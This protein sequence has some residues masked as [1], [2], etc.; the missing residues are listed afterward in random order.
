MSA[1]FTVQR[2]VR[3]KLIRASVLCAG[4]AL[5]AACNPALDWR[6]YHSDEGGYS[7]LL[8]QKPGRAQR[9]LAT[10]AGQVTMQMLSAQ[11]DGML[12]GAASANFSVPPDEATQQAMRA[13]LLKNIDGAVVSD[14]PVT[15]AGNSAGRSAGAPATLT[16]REV[17]KRGSFGSGERAAQG[18][19]RARFF[20]RG[21]RYYQIAAIGSMGAVP[22]ADLDLFFD[23]FK[24]D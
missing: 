9:T 1:R 19:L 16:G 15:T 14:K 3:R 11:V 18:E 5:L 4:A 17:I 6:E 21:N 22:A 2:W 7:V 12:F 10:P 13:A 23:S 8:P 20:V 24:P